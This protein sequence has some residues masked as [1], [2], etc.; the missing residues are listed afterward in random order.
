MIN[1]KEKST[2][3]D[4]RETTSQELLVSSLVSI[5]ENQSRQQ[6]ARESNF[7]QTILEQKVNQNDDENDKKN[8]DEFENRDDRDDHEDL[9]RRELAMSQSSSFVQQTS[10]RD[11]VVNITTSMLD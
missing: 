3:I 11:D 8:Y 6:Y 2:F 5:Y 4:S 1:Q 7:E 10:C 9:E